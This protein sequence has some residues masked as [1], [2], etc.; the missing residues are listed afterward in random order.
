MDWA[1]FWLGAENFVIHVGWKVVA[2][3][4]VLAIIWQTAR[5]WGQRKAG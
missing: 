5:S 4:G 2:L 3:V 1:G